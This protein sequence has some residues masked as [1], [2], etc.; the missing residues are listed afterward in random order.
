MAIRLGRANE[1]TRHKSAQPPKSV[2]GGGERAQ[3]IGYAPNGRSLADGNT[4][5]AKDK[6]S[7]D[8]HDI[9]RSNCR[10]DNAEG[11]IA[12]RV[13]QAAEG[14]FRGYMGKYHDNNDAKGKFA[15]V[16]AKRVEDGKE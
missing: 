11:N 2:F 4:L 7:N 6:G 16:S 8:R 5:R 9:S 15:Y 3:S 10:E 14:A 13:D 12:N 1:L